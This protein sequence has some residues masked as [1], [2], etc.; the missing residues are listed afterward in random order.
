MRLAV[1]KG[2]PH[3]DEDGDLS[4]RKLFSS[5]LSIY[6]ALNNPALNGPA[7]PLDLASPLLLSQSPDWK[8][9][10]LWMPVDLR[11]GRPA[12]ASVLLSA[13]DDELVVLLL[14]PS[15][16]MVFETD[17]EDSEDERTLAAPGPAPTVKTAQNLF[18][19]PRL[20]LQESRRQVTLLAL[21]LFQKQ[22]EQLAKEVRQALAGV[23]V[24]TMVVVQSPLLYD[25][26]L[27]CLSDH[28]FLVNDGARV[29]AEF[30]AACAAHG[31]LRLTVVN[32]LSTNYFVNLFD[33]LS[34]AKPLQ[35]WK[36]PAVPHPDLCARIVAAA[37]EEVA[38]RCA[39]ELQ[40]RLLMYALLVPQ[41]KDYR[42][43]ERQLRTELLETCQLATDPLLLL[44]LLGR[45]R[46]LA[47]LANLW[48]AVVPLWSL[49]SFAVG[50]GLGVCVAGGAA[51]TLL[52]LSSH[53]RDWV[54]PAPP[55]P[56]TA[57]DL[58][59]KAC[60]NVWMAAHKQAASVTR[61]AG[62]LVEDAQALGFGV[63]SGAREV[64]ARFV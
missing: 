51:R 61:W 12:S 40:R 42:V 3:A 13:S 60:G 24:S 44:G 30:V 23:H 2:A 16:V 1:R 15:R 32:V 55:E 28:V 47:T 37:G 9:F 38:L 63:L 14:R 29:F 4:L 39:V 59:T 6:S 43:L 58:C 54:D 48:G 25:A 64:F 45:W 35:V 17:E 56:S 5:H 10:G 18:V 33:I 62:L 52:H 49:V 20:L 19:M 22:T 50:L 46:A 34:A 8:N 7:E 21:A 26:A 41:K 57:L 36:S 27:V 31:Q 53:V 11:A